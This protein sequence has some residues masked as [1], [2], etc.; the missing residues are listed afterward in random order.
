VPGAAGSDGVGLLLRGVTRRFGETVAVAG[1]DLEVPL[2]SRLAGF[3]NRL[4]HQLSGGTRQRVSF[5]RTHRRYRAAAEKLTCAL[6]GGWA[7]GRPPWPAHLPGMAGHPAGVGE[8]TPEEELDLGIGAA[9]LVG[10][11]LGQGV[12]HGWIESQQY[13]LAF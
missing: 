13:A 2:H 6:S 10:R 8:R 7:G 1:I 4:P 11:P 9:H 3:E 5:P 12:V